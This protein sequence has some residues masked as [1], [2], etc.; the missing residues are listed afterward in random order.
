MHEALDRLTGRRVAMKRLVRLGPVALQR[1]KH[2]FRAFVDVDHPNVVRLHALVADEAGWF[3]VMD[4]VDGHD[5]AVTLSGARPST[6]SPET[7]V[8]G[9]EDAPAEAKRELRAVASEGARV[10]FWSAGEAKPSRSEER[11]TSLAPRSEAIRDWDRVRR[12]FSQLAAGVAALHA[13]GR[14]HRDLKPSNVLVTRDD[15]IVIVDF[16]LAVELDMAGATG[17]HLAGTPAYMSPEQAGRRALGPASDWYAVGV[18]LYQALTGALP[19]GGD[20]LA[21]FEAR[22]RS[23][24]RDPRLVAPGVP[25]DLA[26][27]ALALLDA[28]PEARPS[29]AEVLAALAVERPSRAL[30]VPFVGRAEARE[31]LVA[32]LERA[33]RPVHV[34]LEAASGIGKS[35]LLGQLPIVLA[36]DGAAPLV[37]AGRAHEHE[38]VPFKSVDAIV[39]A[40]AGWLATLPPEEA[41]RLTPRHAAELARVFPVLGRAPGF[42]AAPD[43]PDGGAIDDPQ[44]RRLRAGDAFAE[45]I[46]HIGAARRLVLVLDDAQWGDAEG[47]QLLA[48]ALVG[49]LLLVTACRPDSERAPFYATLARAAPELETIVIPLAPLDTREARELARA[50]VTAPDRAAVVARESGGHPFFL[51]Q[52]ARRAA[53]APLASDGSAARDAASVTSLEGVLADRVA[54]LGPAARR[55]LAVAALGGQPLPLVAI[56]EAAALDPGEAEDALRALFRE[57]LLRRLGGERD[58]RVEPSHD[59]VRRLALASHV[60]DEERRRSE[61]ALASALE[62]RHADA[63][64]V[65]FHYHAAGAHARARPF[66]EAAARDA[67]DALAFERAAELYTRAATDQ[68]PDERARLLEAASE[69]WRLAGRDAIAADTLALAA[70]LVDEARRP[71]IDRLVAEL[72]LRAGH[73]DEGL[74][75]LRPVLARAG[76]RLPRTTF[77][78][79]LTLIVEDLRLRRSDLSPRLVAEAD[80]PADLLRR[81]DTNWAA[82]IGLVNTDIVRGIG[83]LF[84][85]LRLALRAGEPTRLVRGLGLAAMFTAGRGGRALARAQRYADLATTTADHLGDARSHV[86]AG[87]GRGMVSFARF[88]WREAHATFEDALARLEADGRGLAWELGT[89]RYFV[90]LLRQTVGDVGLVLADA[91]PW[92]DEARARGDRYAATMLGATFVSWCDL[93]RSR[94]DRAVA[95]ATDMIASWPRD[96]FLLPHLNAFGMTIEAKMYQGRGV[97]ALED[98]LSQ[99]PTVKGSRLLSIEVL[100]IRV[101][102]MIGRAALHATF[103]GDARRPLVEAAVRALAR[104]RAPWPEALA[105]TLSAGLARGDERL[106]HLARAQ[107]GFT[108]AGMRLH[109]RLV[110]LQRARVAGD[111]IEPH[112]A[113]LRA[114]GI[115]DPIRFAGLTVP[116]EALPAWSRPTRS[117][118]A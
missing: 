36:R 52:L 55:L 4:L 14:L 96:R 104:Y 54:A 61:L 27:L 102:D 7:Y 50:L 33:T 116:I 34:R 51:V 21:S 109:A 98:L 40:I 63:H 30:D 56:V 103:G 112:L 3:V 83:F 76:E 101:R 91:P 49:P 38:S 19:Y 114:S 16:G 43:A 48:G 28:R 47:A 82:A 88:D 66:L 115:V 37:F 41:E 90:T 12:L 62:A 106:A 100:D 71:T 107:A 89:V 1:F 24:P 15:Q 74:A 20:A 73:L 65:G 105:A 64:L 11:D 94:P 53:E 111:P 72:H 35:T 44:L 118:S 77:G 92:T 32:A 23:P 75:A 95:Q 69:A 58:E 13:A 5:L 80:V 45:L 25:D 18:M 117:A 87:I 68:A 97:V 31:R 110:A 22:L 46:A 60:D 10:A 9:D 29:A 57:R 113:S 42:A 85:F 84:R 79:V 93:C 2:E 86:W 108:A 70:P 26:E 8:S 6:P 99:M 67:L 17:S 81:I 78:S 59:R 39:D